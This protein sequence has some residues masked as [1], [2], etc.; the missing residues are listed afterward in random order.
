[1]R[2]VSPDTV[3]MTHMREMGYSAISGVTLLDFKQLLSGT[4]FPLLLK[5]MLALLAKV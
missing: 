3:N 4:N 1:M 5:D 2:F